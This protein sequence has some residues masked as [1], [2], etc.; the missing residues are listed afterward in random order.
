MQITDVNPI[1][2]DASNILLNGADCFNADIYALLYTIPGTRPGF[3]DYGI[4][5]IQWLGAT[6][7]EAGVQYYQQI[8]RN[9]L[10]KWIPNIVVNYV[11]VVFDYNTQVLNIVI[12]YTIT[13]N[14]ITFP[15]KFVTGVN[16]GY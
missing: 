8:I 5:V 9:E 15:N 7:D 2:Q 10:V 14:G 12:N 3:P 13:V 4:G 11:E 16:F 1:P 6:F